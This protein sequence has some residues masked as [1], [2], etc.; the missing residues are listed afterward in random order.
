MP[1]TAATPS[2]VDERGVTLVELLIVILIVGSIAGIVLVATTPLQRAAV[3]ACEDAN[4]RM[5]MVADVAADAGVTGDVYRQAPEDCG[6]SPA[7]PLRVA[8][9]VGVPAAAGI[10]GVLVVRRRGLL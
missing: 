6:D 2:T 3:E 8:L 4:R 9:V 10:F 1:S 5:G 7:P